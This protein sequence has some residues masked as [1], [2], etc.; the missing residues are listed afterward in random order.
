MKWTNDHN[1]DFGK[2]TKPSNH[3]PYIYLEHKCK[4]F[5]A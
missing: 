3:I 5:R 2:K 1:I 4:A